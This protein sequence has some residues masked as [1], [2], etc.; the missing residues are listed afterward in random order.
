ML[1][2]GK[3]DAVSVGMGEKCLENLEKINFENYR[4]VINAGVC[5]SVNPDFKL[6]DTVSP[7]KVGS[8]GKFQ[9]LIPLKQVKTF[10]EKLKKAGIKVSGTLQTVKTPVFDREEKQKL[11]SAG[12]DFIDME[13]FYLARKYP[14]LISIKIIT[15]LPSFKEQKEHFVHITNGLERLKSAVSSFLSNL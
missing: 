4:F 7:L 14:F 10:E 9:T 11:F 6:F 13:C 3:L 8:D 15:D 1:Q 2:N 5:G 12:I